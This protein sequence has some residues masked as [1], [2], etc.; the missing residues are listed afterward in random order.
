MNLKN[1]I[2]TEMAVPL[3]E[4]KKR[5]DGLRFQLVENWC[6]LEYCRLYDPSNAN[7]NKNF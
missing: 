1:H 2:I 6:L 3:K 4:Y 7:I 5:L